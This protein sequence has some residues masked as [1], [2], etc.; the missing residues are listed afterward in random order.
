[1]KHK[2]KILIA[3]DSFK[4]ALS[5]DLVCQA[6][7]Q[8]L[9]ERYNDL[10]ISIMPLSDGG[11]GFLHA[12]KSF[13]LQLKKVDSY[14]ALMNKIDC[15]YLFDQ[16]NKIAYIE[17]AQ[18][19]GIQKIELQYRNPLYTTTYGVGCMIKDALCQHVEKIYIG[20]GGSS[21]HDLGLGMASSLGYKFYNGSS[22]I[23]SPRGIDL[24]FI[25]K[26][27]EMSE[28]L[29]EVDIIGVSDVKNVLLGVNGSAR[30]FAYQKGATIEE[31]EKLENYSYEF[32]K[33]FKI[34]HDFLA[35]HGAGA[36][37]GLGF[38]ILYFL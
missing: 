15:S 14:D 34:G 32:V 37:G 11:E 36:A 20:L 6:I 1:M 28:S 8:G 26:F 27:D 38:G 16:K 22:L 21:T 30:T 17:S 33:R 12:L 13:N 9:L 5:A 18:S 2:P 25:D 7:S 3:C 35:A 4:D 24:D 29:R 23:K 19:C 31:V 10:S